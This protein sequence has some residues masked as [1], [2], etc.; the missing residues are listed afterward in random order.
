MT[1]VND[2][3]KIGTERTHPVNEQVQITNCERC[4]APCQVANKANEDARLLKHSTTPSGWCVDCATTNFL[5]TS[6]MGQLIS[7]PQRLLD[8]RIRLQFAKVLLAGMSDA[9][10]TE[11]NWER[12][13]ANWDMPFTKP[14]KRRRKQGS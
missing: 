13:V 1:V 4:G 11:I 7:D 8:P 9:R 3:Y 2:W 5:Q 10:P 12:V 6:P 14:S